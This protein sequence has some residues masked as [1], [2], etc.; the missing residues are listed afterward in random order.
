MA[1]GNPNLLPIA[2]STFEGGT[3]Q[4]AASGANATTT[5]QTTTKLSGTYGLRVTATATG[6]ATIWMTTRVAA[7]AGTEYVARVPVGLAAALAG[8]T[9]RVNIEWWSAVTGGTQVGFK[10]GPTASVVNATGFNNAGYA[11]VADRAPVGATHMALTFT[12]NGLAAGQAVVIDDLYFGA[13]QTI[14]GNMLPYDV[15]SIEGDTSGWT[16]AN[17][18]LDRQAV[19]LLTGSGYYALRATSVAAGVIDLHTSAGFPVSPGIEYVGYGLI[20]AAN[21]VAYSV[22][23]EIRWFNG[24]WAMLGTTPPSVY[25]AGSNPAI[26]RVAAAGRAPAGAVYAQ[27]GHYITTSAGGQVYTAEEFQLKAAANPSG[28][29]LDYDEFSTESALPA[30]TPTNVASHSRSGMESNITDGYFALKVTPAGSGIVGM[31]LNRLLAVT[32]GVTYLVQATSW[33]HNPIPA[34]T[35]DSTFRVRVDWFKADGS[36]FQADNPDQFYTHSNSGEYAA[37]VNNQ[38]RTAPVGA[39]FAKVGLEWSHQ[40]GTSDYYVADNIILTPATPQYSLSTD[41]ATGCVTLDVENGH[42]EP[43]VSVQRMDADGSASYVRGYGL[44]YNRA[45]NSSAPMHIEDYEAPL[46]TSVW[47]AITWYQSDGSRG[48]RLFTRDTNAPVLSDPDYVWLKSPGIPAVN[49][50]VMMEAPIK[51]SR[52]ARSSTYEI[53]GRRNPVHVTGKRAGRT[54]TISVLIWDESA[55]ET[56]DALL[57][58]G[59]PALIQAMPGYGLK[60]NLYIAT[61]DVDSDPVSGAANQEGWRWTLNITEIDRPVGGLQGSAL[62]T[63]ADILTDYDQWEGVQ[64]RGSWQ[65][66]LTEG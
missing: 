66:I 56:F 10:S 9:V 44:E 3:S 58:S 52:A 2:A 60:G 26:I 64:G 54:S 7:S 37:Q 43:T 28:N 42:T 6:E 47:Y 17:A 8:L 62:H 33:R 63:W 32:P 22:T 51:W 53:V 23:S 25:S 57:D 4:W 18:N 24:A 48:T 21:G 49:T 14:F 45:P 27:L 39:A 46:A 29:L 19:S 59:L 15:Q 35:V 20:Y 40:S 31:Q 1:Y 16:A 36:L 30:W 65:N 55:N 11:A 5:V 13:A 50:R 38:T 12:I 41:D 61:K 34:N